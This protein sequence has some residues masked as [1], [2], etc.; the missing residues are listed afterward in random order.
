LIGW[1]HQAD[2]FL[3]VYE[4][5]KNGSLQDHLYSSVSILTWPMR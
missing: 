1:C 5:F 2:E 3:L 4:L